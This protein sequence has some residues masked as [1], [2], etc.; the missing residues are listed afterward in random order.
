MFQEEETGFDQ[1]DIS[2]YQ[3][4]VMQ[5]TKTQST[6]SPFILGKGI[7]TFTQQS[8]SDDF[9][10]KDM[11]TFELLK[12][13]YPTRIWVVPDCKENLIDFYIQTTFPEV[14]ETQNFFYLSQKVK[15]CITKEY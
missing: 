10:C 14:L 13:I 12:N 6:S 7:N 4:A 3:E 1:N 9:N 15:Y 5:T 8:G 2:H 11:E